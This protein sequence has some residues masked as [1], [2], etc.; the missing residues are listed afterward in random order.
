LFVLVP[1]AIFRRMRK[2]DRLTYFD[3]K[4]TSNFVERDHVFRKEDLEKTW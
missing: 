3:P 4:A 1:M 2:K